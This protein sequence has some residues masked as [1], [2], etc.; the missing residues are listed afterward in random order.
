MGRWNDGGWVTA[1]ESR[2]IC[3]KMRRITTLENDDLGSFFETVRPVDPPQVVAIVSTGTRVEPFDLV[4]FPEPARS[5][6]DE[7][8]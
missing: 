8:R 3:Y 7:T 4:P 1:A 6:A 2:V 5:Q